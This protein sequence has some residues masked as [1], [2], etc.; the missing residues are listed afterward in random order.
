[1][2]CSNVNMFF[3]NS[4]Q[5]LPNLQY[6]ITFIILIIIQFHIR[7]LEIYFLESWRTNICIT[8]PPYLHFE[9]SPPHPPHLLYH[10][11]NLIGK[12]NH[13]PKIL[14]HPL[15]STSHIHKSYII[16]PPSTNTHIHFETMYAI[17]KVNP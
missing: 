7:W 11:Q 1:M 9:E 13:H 2:L 4:L 16:T 12:N 3:I 15:C 10:L 5:I 17:N 14:H 8:L 6:L